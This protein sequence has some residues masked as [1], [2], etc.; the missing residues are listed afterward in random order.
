[1]GC[2]ASFPIA[3]TPEI[4]YDDEIDEALKEDINMNDINNNYDLY[5][6]KNDS[7]IYEDPA[8]SSFTHLDNNTY[9]NL[10]SLEEKNVIDDD[11]YIIKKANKILRDYKKVVKYIIKNEKID[12][13]IFNFEKRLV[14]EWLEISRKLSD[15]TQYNT[16]F[17]RYNMKYNGLLNHFNGLFKIVEKRESTGSSGDLSV[18]PTLI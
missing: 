5:N 8:V 2:R 6:Y 9:N 17:N 11:E 3:P 15:N 13:Y 16:K 18:S 7:V 4:D 10:Y 12:N 1:M 14:K